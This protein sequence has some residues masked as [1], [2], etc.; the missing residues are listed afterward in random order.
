MNQGCVSFFMD[1][2]SKPSNCHRDPLTSGAVDFILV[3]LS[4]P[5]PTGFGPRG[6]QLQGLQN[7]ADVQKL[8]RMLQGLRRR[9]IDH[10]LEGRTNV[11]EGGNST[12]PCRTVH[13]KS[14]ISGLQ[15]GMKAESSQDYLLLVMVMVMVLSF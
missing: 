13:D 15:P 3:R 5:V 9:F 11:D 14:P 4:F 2:L 10:G 1:P 7:T 12:Y 6:A 8:L